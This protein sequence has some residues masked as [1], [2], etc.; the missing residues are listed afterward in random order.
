LRRLQEAGY[1]LVFSSPG[2]QPDEEELLRLLP[3]CVG[4]L[5]GVEK[6]SAHVL[7]AAEQLRVISRNG[8]GV[9]NID[10]AAAKQ[11]QVRVCRAEGTNARGVAELAMALMLALV[12]SVP[13][14][15]QRLK[16][17]A[18]ERRE[19]IELEGRTLG[20]IG[21]G[22]I[23]RLVARF[24]LAFDMKVLAYD[25]FPDQSFHPSDCFEHAP[26]ESLWSC[27]DIIS[28]HCPLPADCLPLIGP[29]AL[30]AMK[31]GAYLLNTARAGLLDEEAVLMALDSGQLSGLATDVFREE[32]P[33]DLRL[34]QHS[35]VIATPH[36]GGYTRESVSRAVEAAVDN[37][38][39]AL[40]KEHT[41]S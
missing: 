15:D 24:A 4:Y 25:L 27:A 19:G 17:D 40:V 31:R 3:D 20:L 39:A 7:K 11:R 33:R 1:E 18:W 14:S 5:A 12:R 21:C 6:V 16:E 35:K 26:L 2:K 34:L 13:F 32:P 23:G 10:L 41:K 29:K 36:V 8:T 9:D 28:L 22:R 37:L 30:G 38:L